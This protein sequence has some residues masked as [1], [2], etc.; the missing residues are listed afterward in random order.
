VNNEQYVNNSNTDNN[1]RDMENDHSSNIT[2]TKSPKEVQ[3]N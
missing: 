3:P 1:S 2:T